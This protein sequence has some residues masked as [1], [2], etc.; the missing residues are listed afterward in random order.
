MTGCVR[1]WFTPRKG[2]KNRRGC[3]DPKR[4][5]RPMQKE[6]HSF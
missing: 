4:K 1:V 6:L 5:D 3:N 2:K